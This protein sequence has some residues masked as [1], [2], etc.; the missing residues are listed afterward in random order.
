MEGLVNMSLAAAFKDR[1]VLVTGHTGF[2]GSWLTAWLLELGAQVAGYALPPVGTTPLFDQLGLA[3]RI[4]HD[5]ADIRNLPALKAVVND[6]APDFIFHLAAQPL[7]RLAYREPVETYEV[8]VMGTVNLLEAVRSAR[9]PCTV[10]CV[11][12]DKCYENHEW[13]HSYRETDRLGG[14][15]PYSS[16]KAAAEL[17]A[18]AYRDSYFEGA[19]SGV[20]IATV[21]SGNV[22]GG[23]DWAEDRIVPDCVRA[24]RDGIPV[25]VRN[26]HATR[27]W[28]HVLEPLS[29][30]LHLAT[31]L[32]DAQPSSTLST[33]FNFGPPLS[34]NRSV[35]DLVEELLKHW[36][37]SWVDRTDPSAPHEATLLNLSVE[38]AYHVLGWKPIWSFEETIDHTVSWYRRAL[39]RPDLV[40]QLTLD[41]ISA[42]TR[43]AARDRVA[44]ATTA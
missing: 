35:G 40:P 32:T 22:I 8:N 3:A 5:I 23:G 14:R 30:Y 6:F 7:V 29:G 11:T 1:R 44:W 10:V 31:R 21:R 20:R 19:H 13:V 25:V 41:Q 38:K 36:P 37:G 27:P 2:K 24:L 26:K 33:A 42:Y 16:S 18:R 9:R 15:D 43:E 12:T 39:K 34:S 4:R 17:V 28:Q